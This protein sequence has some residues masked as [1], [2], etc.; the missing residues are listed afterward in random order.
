MSLFKIRWQCFICK[1]M[2]FKG[3][4]GPQCWNCWCRGWHSIETVLDGRSWIG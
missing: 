2:G 4:N 1:G 3:H